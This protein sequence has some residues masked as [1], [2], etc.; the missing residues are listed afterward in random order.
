MRTF[1]DAE[2]ID[3]VANLSTFQGFPNGMLDICVRS[4][5][6]AFDRFD[7]KIFTYECFGDVREPNFK[8]MARGTTNA[9]SFG[10]FNYRTY[11]PLGCAVLCADT[12]VL[13]SHA[14]GLHKRKPGYVQVKGIPYTRDH[15]K[16]RRAE[17]YGKIYTD[18]I[19]ANRH[20]AGKLSHVIYNWSVG[21][22][23]NQEESVFLKWLELMNKR[24]L[25]V[26]ILNEW[27]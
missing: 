7:D 15:N 21:C 12:I 10:L 20:R 8:M 4:S 2:L 23:V 11:N 25:S 1:T 3:R 26:A 27:S 17:N 16:N 13:N 9:G 22:I 24:P 5:A 14:A 19:L 6:D 18:I